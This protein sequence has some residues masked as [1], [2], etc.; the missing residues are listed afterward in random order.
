[1]VHLIKLA[2]GIRDIDHLAERQRERL[3]QAADRGEP[4]KLRHITRH[5]PKRAEELKE[6]GSIYWVIRGFVRARQRI[7]DIERI[8]AEDE[9][10]RCALIL[11]PHLVATQ[12]RSM[13]AFQGWRYLDPAQAPGDSDTPHGAAETAEMPE[14]MATALR[15]LG[16]L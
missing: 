1:M 11:D 7:L 14:S 16:L 13:R 15:D 4:G 3:S 9:T 10:K 8:T 6:N 5:V 2:V 12:I